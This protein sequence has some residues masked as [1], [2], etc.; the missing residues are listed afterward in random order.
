MRVETPSRVVPE[1]ETGTTPDR[2][3]TPD[4]LCPDQQGRVVRRI[5]REL[6]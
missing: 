1:T 5:I 3:L 6:P 4:K 2:R